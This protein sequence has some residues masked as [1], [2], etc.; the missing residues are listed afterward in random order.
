VRIALTSD[1][2][3]EH[4]PEVIGLV[5][6]RVRAAGGV[7]VLIVAGDVSSDLGS[8][9]R[10]L[11]EL[12]G[13]ARHAVFVPG[14]HD[15]WCLRDSPSSRAR[16]EE[17]IPRAVRAAGFHPL[18]AEPVALDGVAFAGVTGWYDYTL[19]NPEMDQTFTPDDYRR[20]AWGRL[21]WNDK[22]RIDWPGDDGAPLD[23]VAICAAQVASLER[24]LAACE[25]PGRSTRS[26]VVVTHHLPFRELVTSRGELPWDFLNGFMGSARLGDA[27]RRSPSVRLACAGHTHY[28]KQ[29]S[30]EGAGGAIRV[31]VSPVGYPREYARVLGLTLAARVADRVTLLDLDAQPPIM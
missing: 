29:A 4:H 11:A 14:N 20:G 23:D 7:D 2:H 16:Y 9:E 12:R 6:E 24:Q 17:A 30:I 15:L 28:R 26:T 8:L 19:R 1:L 21:R 10:S 25:E 27:I 5:A 3:V 13:T 18:G 31:E 22:A